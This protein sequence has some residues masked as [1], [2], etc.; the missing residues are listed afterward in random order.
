MREVDTSKDGFIS[1]Q[2]FKDYLQKE[3]PN[4]DV[5]Q[6]S[7]SSPILIESEVAKILRDLFVDMGRSEKEVLPYVELFER[8]RLRSIPDLQQLQPEDWG[9]LQLP[10]KL[11]RALRNLVEAEI[12]IQPKKT[13]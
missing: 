12:K 3:S 9:R 4:L 2:E 13:S 6:A 1:Y 10:L 7:Y 5:A 8:N 11:E